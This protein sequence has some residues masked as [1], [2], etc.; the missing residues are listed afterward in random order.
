MDL[1]YI[2]CGYDE[3]P[4][5]EMEGEGMETLEADFGATYLATKT[6]VVYRQVG[7]RELYLNFVAPESPGPLPLVVYVQGSAFHRQDVD[8]GLGRLSCFAQRGYAIASVEYR[9]SDIAPFPAQALDTKYAIQYLVQH[10]GELNVDPSKILLWGDSSGG[11]TVLMTA[12]TRGVEG[13]VADDLEEYPIAGVVDYYGPISFYDMNEQPSMQNHRDPDSPEGYE[14]GKVEVTA[15]NSKVADVREYIGE[16]TPP[17]LIVHGDK[18]RLVPFGQSCLLNDALLAA[19]KSV[20]FYR[21]HG[22]DHAGAP[23]WAPEVLDIVDSFM[24]RCIA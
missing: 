17:V 11:H 21:L 22:A 19:G 4:F 9:E 7:D 24:R 16:S 18:D 10:A 5:S 15:G 2:D 20:E 23:F 6:H 3:F 1:R 12:F 8:D 14:L 13:I